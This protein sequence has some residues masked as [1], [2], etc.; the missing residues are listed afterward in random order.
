MIQQSN[1]KQFADYRM[2]L[3]AHVQDSKKSNPKWTY[4]M[5]IRR[6]GLNDVS[7]VAKIIQ[8]TREPGPA[9][10]EKFVKYF[11]FSEKDAQ[12]FRDLIRLHKIKKDPRLS[13]LLLEK[14]AKDHPDARMQLLD[15]KQ[16]SLISNW[17]CVAIRE[18]VRMDVFF[19]DGDWISKKLEFKVTPREATKAIELLIQTGLLQRK[20]DGNL[21]IATGRFGTSND[22]SSEAIK[23]YHE[24][25]LEN[26]KIALRKIDVE[27]REF[28]ASVLT[29]NSNKIA[30]A[31]L[32]IREFKEKFCRLLEE[33]SANGTFQ[34]Q[35][36]FFPLTKI[37]KSS[38][39]TGDKNED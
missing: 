17:Y 15:D 11:R 32:L 28:T 39:H 23:R 1:I 36:Q 4:G 37:D 12:Y 30:E 35:I 26:A 5:W 2:F 18:M 24:S 3:L 9:I 10:T 6:L 27:K 25:M 34:I 29:M 7:S 33:D 20:P 31:K 22:L 8:G 13:V 38:C 16:F 21:E 19:E 14:M